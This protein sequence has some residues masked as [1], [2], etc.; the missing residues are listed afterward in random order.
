MPSV[1]RSAVKKPTRRRR[2]RVPCSRLPAPRS[3]CGALRRRVARCGRSVRIRSW[4]KD[5]ASRAQNQI[6]LVLPRRRLSKRRLVLRKVCKLGAEPNL[7]GILPRCR[8]SKRRLCPPQSVQGGCRSDLRFAKLG[9]PFRHPEDGAKIG[10]CR[11]CGPKSAEHAPVA[12]LRG[13]RLR[14][15]RRSAPQCCDRGS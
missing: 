5:S 7:F 6:Y 11:S 3:R 2:C 9:I 10:C 13:R 8:L 12:G 14:P 1:S 4:D 15:A